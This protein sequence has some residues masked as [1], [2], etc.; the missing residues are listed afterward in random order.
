MKRSRI[1][2][3]L[4]KAGKVRLLR[5]EV[6]GMKSEIFLCRGVTGFV[7]IRVEITKKGADHTHHYEEID[8]QTVKKLQNILARYDPMP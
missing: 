7:F 1:E 2:N 3:N 5:S 8:K 6:D 4:N